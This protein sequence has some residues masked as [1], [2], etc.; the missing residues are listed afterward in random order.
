MRALQP[1]KAFEGIERAFEGRKWRFE[2]LRASGFFLRATAAQ[3]LGIGNPSAQAVRV[4]ISPRNL[5]GG[6]LS[7]GNFSQ[8][9]SPGI[10]RTSWEKRFFP[11]CPGNSRPEVPGDRP[12][13]ENT[14]ALNPRGGQP[15][16]PWHLSGRATPVWQ[17]ARR[18][19]PSD[20]PVNSADGGSCAESD[21]ASPPKSLRDLRSG[22]IPY[23]SIGI[24]RTDCNSSVRF[25]NSLARFLQSFPGFCN[26]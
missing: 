10:P 19:H 7:G 5:R 16:C 18:T 3:G 17:T 23:T 21:Q 22:P 13:P 11:G 25:R 15:I 12:G 6:R 2:R 9:T 20:S 4:S 24:P 8:A 14:S 26:P 1:S